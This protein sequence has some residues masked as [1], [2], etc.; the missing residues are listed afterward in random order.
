MKGSSKGQV[1]LE[2]LVYAGVFLLIAVSAYTLTYFTQRGEVA[3]RESQMFREFGYK[4]QYAA[5][6]AYRGGEGFT[7]DQYFTEKLDGKPYD[8]IFQTNRNT[9]V[10]T[11][12]TVWNGTSSEY[13][14][15]YTIPYAT[16]EQGTGDC[17]KDSPSG[18]VSIN[19]GKAN[20][21][22]L[23]TNLDGEGTP[24]IQIDCGVEG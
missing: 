18:S 22:L 2:F 7:Y 3:L 6:V 11:V 12:K 19:V 9:G 15:L 20:G 14:Y 21:R 23:F 16:Y 17:F 5:I 8:L 1:A 24:R 4:F 10:S 13:A